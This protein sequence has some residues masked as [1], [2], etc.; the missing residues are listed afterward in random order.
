MDQ[1]EE[2]GS[3]GDWEE[4]DYEGEREISSA[5]ESEESEGETSDEDTA[6]YTRR[7]LSSIR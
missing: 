2:H 5:G 3:G 1:T 4:E 7:P 6:A